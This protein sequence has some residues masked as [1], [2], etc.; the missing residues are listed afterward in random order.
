MSRKLNDEVVRI[1][2]DGGFSVSKKCNIH[3][4]SFDHVAKRD[5]LI[6]V[7]KVL[8]DINGLREEIARRLI[9][10]S[11][12][13]FGTPFIIGEKNRGKPMERGIAYERHGIKS[14]SPET[15]RDLVVEGLPPVVYSAPGG[16]YAKI[17]SD[18][19]KQKRKEKNLSRG[20]LASKV[21]VS[22]GTIRKYEEGSDVNR[23]IAIKLERELDEPLFKPV[24][25]TYSNKSEADRKKDFGSI[26]HPSSPSLSLLSSLGVR[27]LP[28]N[29]APFS[30]LSRIE[31]D[32]FLTGVEN[33][34]SRLKKK[35]D[36]ISSVSGTIDYRSF[37]VVKQKT[38]KKCNIE[39]TP[40]VSEGELTE[41]KSEYELVS[42]I[43]EREKY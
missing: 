33:Y 21:G 15:L 39:D 8:L 20:E 12:M 6:F 17:D 43:E 31:K 28:A 32:I 40:L 26:E 19:L 22:R 5:D 9:E 10:I 1:L 4:K 30:A 24:D 27:I 18:R 13:L 3:P 11:H 2:K 16:N 38:C 35:A 42:L 25:L 34:N 41:I 29:K 14:L 36:I 7:L 23:G 37:M